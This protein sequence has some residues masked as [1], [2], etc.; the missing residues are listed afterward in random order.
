MQQPMKTKCRTNNPSERYVIN[1]LESKG[2]E[3]LKR[4]WPD[5]IAV[6]GNTVRFIEVKRLTRRDGSLSTSQL[7]PQQKRVAE[8]LSKLGIEVELIRGL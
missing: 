8:I 7:K 2:Y 3:V 6:K 5:L 1:D 4:G